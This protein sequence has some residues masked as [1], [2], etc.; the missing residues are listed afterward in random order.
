MEGSAFLTK[1]GFG[2][3]WQYFPWQLLRSAHNKPLKHV[4]AAKGA[5]S[6][7]LTTLRFVRRLA[8]RYVL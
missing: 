7:G 6:T 5:T 8:G 4:P 3:V 1:Y 2:I